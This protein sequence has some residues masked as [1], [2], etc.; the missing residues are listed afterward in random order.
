MT[1]CLK[2]KAR[3]CSG[4]DFMWLQ[5]NLSILRR[6]TLFHPGVSLGGVAAGEGSGVGVCSG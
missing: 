5:I 6:L 3:A 4:L 1:I 2:I